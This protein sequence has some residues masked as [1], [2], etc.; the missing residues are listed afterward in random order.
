MQSRKQQSATIC[1]TL[2]ELIGLRQAAGNID[3]SSHKKVMSNRV[4]GFVSGFRGR[5]MDF[6]EVRAYQP[7]DDIRNMDWRVTARSGTPHTKVYREER[8]RPIYVLVDFSASMFFGTKVTFKSVI[9]AKA[10]AIIAWAGVANG[11]RV[12]GILFSEYAAVEVKPRTRTHGVLPLLNHLAQYSQMNSD[13]SQTKPVLAENLLKLRRVV[14]PGSLIFLFSD[15]L[16]LN[17]DAKAYL[18][19]LAH[20]NEIVIG[21]VSDPIEIEAPEPSYYQISD[22]QRQMLMDT[23]KVK[24][25]QQYQQIFSEREQALQKFCKQQQIWLLPMS[26]DQDVA[27]VLSQ[28][29]AQGRGGK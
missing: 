14:K 23:A 24:F 4:G 28:S 3:L 21:H 11:D 19:R 9:A 1:V 2:P 7:G 13:F 18:S 12:G 27:A 29:L 26:T 5:G 8:E 6:E 15:M 16:T 10:A 25:R 22:G 17:D 20:H